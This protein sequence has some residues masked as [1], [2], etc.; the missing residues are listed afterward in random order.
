VSHIDECRKKSEFGQSS[1]SPVQRTL[2]RPGTFWNSGQI[3]HGHIIILVSDLRQ[4]A[5]FADFLAI[6]RMWFFLLVLSS[7]VVYPFL[8]EIL[9]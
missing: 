8:P 2:L 4:R 1:A 5:F 7:R 6:L 3:D 9:T